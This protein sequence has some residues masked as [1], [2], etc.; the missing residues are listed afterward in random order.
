LLE[1]TRRPSLF[2]ITMTADVLERSDVEA[3][4][5]CDGDDGGLFRLC[6]FSAIQDAMCGNPLESRDDAPEGEGDPSHVVSSSSFAEALRAFGGDEVD[7]ERSKNHALR[8]SYDSPTMPR[9]SGAKSMPSSPYSEF[10]LTVAATSKAHGSHSRPVADIYYDKA[11][12][13]MAKGDSQSQRLSMML[14]EEAFSIYQTLSG[15]SDNKTILTRIQLGRA[16]QTAGQYDV[17]LD[18]LCTAVYMREALLGE[19]HPGVSE[20]W[21][22]ISAIHRDRSKL[23][24]ALKA[25]AKALTGYRDAHGDKHP[26][27]IEVLKTI[28]QIHTE[29]GNL[30]KAADITKYV[31]L[32]A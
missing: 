30:D 17:A 16:N 10:T 31:R 24:L 18:H 8:N 1:L 26:L 22:L 13:C 12:E 11:V 3:S 21:V 14:L 29:L 6:E 20:I 23:E 15:D 2:G 25:S 27:V 9:L 5:S 28:A 32:H 4:R 7:M 19:L